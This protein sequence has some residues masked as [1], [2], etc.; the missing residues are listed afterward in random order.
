M[1]YQIQSLKFYLRKTKFKQ[2]D[3]QIQSLKFYLGLTKNPNLEDKQQGSKDQKKN[4]HPFVVF[5]LQTANVRPASMFYI[6]SVI[7]KLLKVCLY[8]YGKQAI[9]YINLQFSCIINFDIKLSCITPSSSFCFTVQHVLLAK[10]AKY[11]TVS[12]P[13]FFFRWMV[14]TFSL[15]SV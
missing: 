9:N 1:D 10:M 5:E 11:F 15:I 7:K 3:Y 2:M 4:S 12:N 14:K 13:S 6:F 8:I